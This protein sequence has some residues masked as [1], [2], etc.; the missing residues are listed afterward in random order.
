MAFILGGIVVHSF[1]IVDG[2][3]TFI[4]PDGMARSV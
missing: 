2:C 4:H 1:I 3:G